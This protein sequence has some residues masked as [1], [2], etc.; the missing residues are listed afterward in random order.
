MLIQTPHEARHLA[1]ELRQVI[2]NLMRNA[3]VHTPEG[4]PILGR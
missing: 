4:T 1:E 3:V 2:A